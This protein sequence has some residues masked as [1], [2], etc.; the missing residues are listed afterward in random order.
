MNIPKHSFIRWI[1]MY[2]RILTR[3][4]LAKMGICQEKECLLCRS[5]P[6]SI[7][8]LFFACE[9]SKECLKGVLEW[10]KIGIKNTNIDGLWRRITRK[11]KG[12]ISRSLIKAIIALL[13][14]HIWRARNG[15]LWNKAVTRPAKILKMIKE[16]SRSR[17]SGST[18]KKHTSKDATWIDNLFK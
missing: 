15:A 7:N 10:L 11:A 1:V 13:I 8:H 9:F 3:D 6:E 17:T 5:E 18:Q 2:R 12:M 4:R 14:Y 16:E